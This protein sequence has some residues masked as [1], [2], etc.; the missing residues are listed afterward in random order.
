[1]WGKYWCNSYNGTPMSNVWFNRL[2]PCVM[3]VHRST[4]ESTLHKTCEN[5]S[6]HWPVF[7]RIRTKSYILSLY[8]SIQSVKT[9][10]L[11]YFMQCKGKIACL[12][13]LLI[14]SFCCLNKINL[15]AIWLKSNF[16]WIAFWTLWVFKSAF[17]CFLWRVFST[18]LHCIVWWR[19]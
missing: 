17:L 2:L 4:S 5:A 14:I 9:R 16:P 15:P 12:I 8:G 19:T 10:I 6:F 7:S 13:S 3:W 1:M 18:I 11:A